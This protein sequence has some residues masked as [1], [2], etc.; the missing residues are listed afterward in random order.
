MAKPNGVSQ[1]VDGKRRCG[2]ERQD[3]SDMRVEARQLPQPRAPRHDRR[4]Q[5]PRAGL[6]ERSRQSLLDDERADEIQEKRDKHFVDAA[7]KM[8]G[9]RDR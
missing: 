1:R 9:R 2:G 5:E 8:D 3:E 7:L 4:L 6:A